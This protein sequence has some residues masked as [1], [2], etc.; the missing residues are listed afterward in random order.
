MRGVGEGLPWCCGAVVLSCSGA[1]V[2]DD[3]S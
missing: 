3:A 1:V 2:E